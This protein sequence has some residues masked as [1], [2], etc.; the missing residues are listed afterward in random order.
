MHRFLNSTIRAALLCAC[1]WPAAGW[2][3]D[4][5]IANLGSQPVKTSDVKDF[6]DG[7][8]PQQ[9]EQAAKDPKVILQLVRSAIGRKLVLDEAGKQSWDKK[10]DVAAQIART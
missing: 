5:V 2:A 7:L 8:N 10:P 3:D 9:R 6:L 1:L 4:D